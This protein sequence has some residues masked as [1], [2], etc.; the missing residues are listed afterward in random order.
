MTLIFY[1]SIDYSIT[2]LIILLLDTFTITITITITIAT[3]ITITITI[4]IH[5]KHAKK[6]KGHR[7]KKIMAAKIGP[8]CENPKS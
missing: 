2:R 8:P 7:C 5:N 6:K 4:T 3:T 1:Y